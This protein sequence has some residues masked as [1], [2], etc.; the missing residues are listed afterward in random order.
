MNRHSRRKFLSRMAAGWLVL[1]N[2]Q[3][4][5][6]Q[7]IIM[8]LSSKSWAGASPFC[9]RHISI[10]AAGGPARWMFD[11]FLSPYDTADFDP[12]LN[13]MLANSFVEG[14]RYTETAY[15]FYRDPG[16]GVNLPWLWQFPVAAPNGGTRPL[17]ALLENLLVLQGLNTGNGGH[18][19]SQR[20]H[21]HYR[22]GRN[23]LSSIAAAHS[24]Q[25]LKG[26]VA[27]PYSF[28]HASTSSPPP[29]FLMTS[30]QREQNLIKSLMDPFSKALLESRSPSDQKNALR[31]A[32]SA[33]SKQALEGNPDAES[34]LQNSSQAQI[35][36]E[37]VFT[38]D[39][40]RIWHDKYSKYEDLIQRTIDMGSALGRLPLLT[41]RPIGHQS[42]RGVDYSYAGPNV[43][44]TQDDLRS[45]IR[46]GSTYPKS[47]AAHFALAEFIVERD[48]SNY[49]SLAPAEFAHVMDGLGRSQGL[50]AHTFDEHVLGKFPSLVL[51]SNYHRA[52]AACLLELIN[53][54][55]KMRQFEHTVIDV[56]GDFNRAP[57]PDG[58]GSD[59]GWTGKSVSIYSGAFNG[60]PYIVGNIHKN[61][62]LAGS[63]GPWGDGAGAKNRNGQSLAELS[64]AH[65]HAT[66]AHL[67]NGTN[68]TPEYH[69]LVELKSNKKLE[70][71]IEPTR[72]V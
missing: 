43:L 13:P 61:S 39:S 62:T 70:L 21:Y 12:S 51:N 28:A 9:R 36:L 48:L 64:I 10:M 57:R 17:T 65:Y 35:L 50:N 4:F 56:S 38:G 11:L 63:P 45:M 49:I 46:A 19:A 27:G 33:L 15:R 58:S 5:F 8:G 68:P 55:K 26:I 30:V 34:I 42:V 14:S 60:G 18:N 6:A 20:F 54:L 40:G 22:D 25:K 44:A 2:T 66:A 31:K 71:L 3:A 37:K 41:D 67:L 1:P 72:L 59:H 52:Q 32:L 7:S 69:S 24:T 47:M 23:S 16:S 29:L 53:V